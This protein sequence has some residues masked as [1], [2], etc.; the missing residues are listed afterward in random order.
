MRGMEDGPFTQVFGGPV[1]RVLD[2]AL[3]VG[4]MEQTIPLMAESTGLSFKTVQKAIK[5]L[6]KFGLVK[7]SRKI[8]NAQTYRFDVGKDLHELIM[9]AEHLKLGR[10]G[11]VRRELRR[12]RTED[13][14]RERE[15]ERRYH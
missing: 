7:K 14:R 3:Y 8:G 12:G 5:Q 4:N 10:A 13:S 9:W 15:L 2:Q 6:N 11:I 1:A